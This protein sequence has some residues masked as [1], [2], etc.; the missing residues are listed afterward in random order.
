MYPM[1]WERQPFGDL[2]REIG[3][4]R[5]EV[6]RIVSGVIQQLPFVGRE[7]AAWQPSI[8][9]YETDREVVLRADLPGVDP[10]ELEVEVR[11]GEVI[12]RGQHREEKEAR[13]ENYYHAERRY[14][15][16]FRRVSL[17]VPV[18]AT[19]AKASY[20]NGVLEVRVP[21]D[22]REK[23]YRVPIEE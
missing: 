6:D 20:K 3:R 1:R 7:G 13:T 19:E 11:E 21:K 17:P 2:M 14:G 4:L 5:E 22:I 10:K 9:L 8:E 15:S 16:F 12:I 18:K 23:G